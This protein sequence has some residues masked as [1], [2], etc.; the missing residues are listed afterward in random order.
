VGE[1]EFILT[2]WP[3]E[4]GQLSRLETVLVRQRKR[5]MSRSFSMGT[6]GGGVPRGDRRIPY[7]GVDVA[8]FRGVMT[9]GPAS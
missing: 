6:R 5:V 4:V 1:G 7:E 2:E 3:A 9:S 8:G